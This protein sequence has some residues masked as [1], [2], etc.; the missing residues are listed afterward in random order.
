MKHLIL[1]GGT[2]YSHKKQFA[3]LLMKQMD[4]AA[5]L[6]GAW[7]FNVDPVVINSTNQKMCLDNICFLLNNYIQNPNVENI[8]FDWILDDQSIID[9]ITSGLDLTDV[10]VTPVSLL[11]SLQAVTIDAQ[12]DIEAG[13]LSTDDL[14]KII[15]QMLKYQPLATIKYD[16]SAMSVSEVVTEIL[17]QV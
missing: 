3:Q 15:A 9:A 17:G 8:I 6:D 12:K 1:I 4:H 16:T 14:P 5:L 7:C 13:N 2:N 10:A 11:P